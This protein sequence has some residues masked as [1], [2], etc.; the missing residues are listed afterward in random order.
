M[1]YF[2]LTSFG[3][4]RNKK[5][6]LSLLAEAIYDAT[7][8]PINIPTDKNT[9]PSRK[10]KASPLSLPSRRRRSGTGLHRNKRPSAAQASDR[11]S[12]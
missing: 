6:L 5:T 12:K 3:N 7:R 10:R 9:L 8:A 4:F 11:L 2:A 1:H